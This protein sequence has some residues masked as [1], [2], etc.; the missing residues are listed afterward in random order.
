MSSE[1]LLQWGG[2]VIQNFSDE[3]IKVLAENPNVEYIARTSFA[4]TSESKHGVYEGKKEGKSILSIL[5]ESLN[6]TRAGRCGA[7]SPHRG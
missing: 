4:F 3:D 7:P 1:K 5:R 2:Q 6:K